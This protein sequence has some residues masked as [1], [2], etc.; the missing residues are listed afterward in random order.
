[1]CGF[2]GF[3]GEVKNKEE[4]LKEMMDTIVHRGPDSQGS[5]LDDNIALGFRRLSIIDLSESGRQPLF[6]EDRTLVLVFNGEIYNYKELK[7]ELISLGHDFKS[8]TDSETILHGFEEWGKDLLNKLRGMYAF[9]IW[10]TKNKEIFAARDIFGIKPFYYANMDQTFFFGSEIKSFLKHPNFEKIFNKDVLPL[11]LSFQFVPTNETFFK[12]VFCLQPG[13]YLTYKDNK[14]TIKRYFKPKFTEN[15]ENSFEKVVE[16]TIKIMKESVAAHKESDVEIGSYLSSGIDSSYLAF[17]GQVEHT[18]TVGFDEGECSEIGEAKEFAKAVGIK[19]HAKV[20]SPDE[21]WDSLSK[22]QYYMDEPIADPSLIALY[23]LSK[24]ASSRVKVVFS[25]EGSDEFFGG[26]NIYTEPLRH[27]KIDKIPFCIRRLIS[28]FAENFLPRGIKGR[29]FL[30]RHGKTLQER[31][32][33][34]ATNVFSEKEA[35]KILKDK[36]GLKVKGIT[37]PLYKEVEDKDA[38][39]QMQ[40]L[41]LHL[42]LVHDILMKGD[43][44]G[45]ANSIEVRV[46]FLDKKVFEFARTLPTEYKVL[47][48]KKITKCALR[49]AAKRSIPEKTANKKKL[50]FPIPIR[51]W[52]REDKYYKR[53]KDAFESD[54]AKKFFNTEILIKMLEGFKNGKIK[55]EKADDSRRIWAIYIFLLWYNR[56]FESES[57]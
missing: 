43:K 56:F 8:N 15:N 1:M 7:A 47:A 42:W 45:M 37:A 27:N 11:Y 36:K 16:E 44:M 3:T 25:G 24:E 50:G 57:I 41:D 13:H 6:N 29:G 55:N 21:Y 9:V 14:L 19:N 4:I 40:Y 31:Y 23:F 10:D 22:I 35:Y 38:V 51:T 26:Y 18:F 52:L 17:L 39:T 34:N 54:S 32:F 2:V 46:P 20:I 12:N 5:Y 33:G 53:V 28:K 30:I 49:E 48:S